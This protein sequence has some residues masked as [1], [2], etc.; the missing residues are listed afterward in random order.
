MSSTARGK[1]GGG[2]AAAAAKKV[3]TLQFKVRG[4]SKEAPGGKASKCAQPHR[5]FS[6]RMDCT[7]NSSRAL[8]PR[9]RRPKDLLELGH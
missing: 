7:L 9:R 8:Q 2:S 4:V 3:R 5:V 1:A 6:P